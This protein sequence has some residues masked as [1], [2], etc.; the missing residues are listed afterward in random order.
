MK[1]LFF[2]LLVFGSIPLY[3]QV[4]NELKRQPVDIPQFYIDVIS[5]FSDDSLHSRVDLYSQVPYDALQF[6][7]RSNQF[8]AKYDITFSFLDSDNSLVMEKSWTEEVHVSDFGETQSKL[9]YNLAERSVLISPGIYNLKCTLRDSESKKTS[10]IVKKVVVG[11][12][13]YHSLSLSDIMLVKKIAVNGDIKKI[14]PNISGNIGDNNNSFALF[15]EIYSPHI[16]D[17][18]LIHY[19]INDVKGNEIVNRT[20]IYRTLSRRTQ[21]IT[22]FDSTEYTIGAYTITVSAHSYNDSTDIVPILKQKTFVVRWGNSPMNIVDLDLAIRQMR[23]IAHD[24]EYS[25]IQDAKTEKEKRKLFEDFWRRRDPNPD[26][27]RNEFMEDYYARV[28]YANSHF[29]N[30]LAG[31]RTDMGMVYIMLGPPNSVERHPFDI[32][33]KPY[34]I[35]SYYDYNRQIVFMDESGFGDYRLLTPIWDILRQLKY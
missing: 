27:K 2:V 29:S 22:R 26:T 31:W 19:I 14:T 12:Y 34:E 25:R 35:W 3:S 15:F 9:E 20:K 17:S 28:Q 7:K 33:A 16:D 1:K 30:Y 13:S 4:E 24:D 5:F 23:Y 6:V 8:E 21:I 11:N 10:L 32:D 18:I